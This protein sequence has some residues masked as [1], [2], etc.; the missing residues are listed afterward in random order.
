[1]RNPKLI[2]VLKLDNHSEN[3]SASYS[4]I[5]SQSRCTDISMTP[6]VTT[7]E[8]CHSKYDGHAIKK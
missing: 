7:T 8:H 4:A 1:M 2:L 3:A 6:P 5:L